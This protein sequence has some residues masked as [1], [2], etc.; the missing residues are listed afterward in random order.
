MSE[1]LSKLGPLIDGELK[2]DSTTRLL[3][4]T[5]AS[6][7]REIPAGVVFPKNANDIQKIVEFCHNHKFP[8]IARG[9]GTS[10]AGQVV[11][12]GLI[13]DTSRYLTKILELKI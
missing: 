6:V 8:I 3:Y 9:A 5:D 1:I 7:Y 12:K 2:L 4:S 13:M 11:G 10:L